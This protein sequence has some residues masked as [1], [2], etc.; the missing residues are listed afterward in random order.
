MMFAELSIDRRRTQ[1]LLK[2]FTAATADSSGISKNVYQPWLG[3]IAK[4]AGL[5]QSKANKQLTHTVILFSLILIGALAS[6]RLLLLALL[7]LFALVQYIMLRSRITRRMLAFERDYAAMLLSLASSIRT[8]LDPL[9]ALMGLRELFSKGSEVRRELEEL[10]ARIE[11]G[12]IEEDAVR[13]FGAN[14][15]HP[16]IPLF[17]TAFI[18]ARKEGSSLSECLQ[19]LA[20]VTRTRQS[21]RR[22]VRS[23]VAMQKLSSL[24]IGLCTLVIGVI[25]FTANPQ[26]IRTALAHPVGE[27]LIG[28]GL[29]LVVIGIAWMY[30]LA[31][32]KG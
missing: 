25:Q 19:R 24:G 26:A 20:R 29:I 18:L 13:E 17:T 31:S 27:K 30:R 12:A 16:D 10:V 8:G 9:V 22:K 4:H 5:S 21:F 3:K 28:L 15:S 1:R 32:P 11:A 14:I 6:G 7:P 2:G 23:A